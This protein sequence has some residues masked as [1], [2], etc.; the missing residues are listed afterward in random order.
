MSLK[1]ENPMKNRL[2][3]QGAEPSQVRPHA[4]DRDTSYGGMVCQ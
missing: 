1:N 4:G 2:Q 3:P